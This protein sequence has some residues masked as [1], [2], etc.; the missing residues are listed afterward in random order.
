M[1]R[2]ILSCGLLVAALA[3]VACGGSDGGATDPGPTTDIPGTD[4]G[5]DA[6][7]DPGLPEDPGT[8]QDFPPNPDVPTDPG[9]LD[10]P[11]V[12]DVPS[13]VAPDAVWEVVTPPVPFG[14]ENRGYTV[15]RGI[16]HLH[17]RHSHDGCWD[18]PDA[19]KPDIAYYDACQNELREAPCKSGVS[20][21]MLTD[22]PSNSRH[23]TFEDL[24]QHMA[25]AGD[26]MIYDGQGRPFANRIACP[27]GS[28]VE[29]AYFF[30][31]TEGSKQMPV[32]L[33]G[34]NPP[35]ELPLPALIFD[36][37]VADEAPLEAAQAHVATVHQQDGFAFVC[38][39]EQSDLSVERI[40]A[41]PLD[42]IEIFNFH[43]ALMQALTGSI[44]DLYMLDR[45]MGT[46][47]NSA[48]PDLSILPFLKP[49]ANDTL[50][51]DAAVPHIRLTAF[52]ATDIHRNVQIPAAICSEDWCFADPAEYPH[53]ARLLFLGGPA[54]L[55]DGY[56]MD[57]YARS[58]RWMANHVLVDD[59]AIAAEAPAVLPDAMRKATGSGRSFTSFDLVGMPLGFDF[60]AVA[61]GE[62]VEMGREIHGAQDVTLYF[63]A[64]TLV[65]PAWGFG[66]TADDP[67]TARIV[68][69]L[70]RATAEGSEVV[71][72][73][74]GQGRTFAWPVQ[75][76]GVFRVEVW[77]TPRH[78]VPVLPRV[79]SLA[80][81]D[82]PYI[83]SNAVFVRP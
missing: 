80:D 43:P 72:Q 34:L 39:P 58:F 17:S 47:D 52:G 40:I 83:Y 23:Q 36:Q 15:L 14:P 54:I 1:S 70:I 4:N 9:T 77:V 61:D 49:I 82:Y 19:D 12:Q 62:P 45:F 6:A 42:G 48:N 59:A 7:D 5:T 38:H 81:R 11:P 56:Q 55:S 32:G 10:T 74:E 26:Q 3:L 24:V 35:Q 13:D 67:A 75:D 50:K 27:P 22:H 21:M 28:L 8:T 64:P 60:F 57:G 53:L 79:E 33:A 76:P 41:L 63:R 18:G 29:H 30:A 2:R 25:D 66:G 16:V 78:L 20:F 31:G 44:D 69:K 65:E 51:F 46:P 71:L 73:A 37:N 68:T